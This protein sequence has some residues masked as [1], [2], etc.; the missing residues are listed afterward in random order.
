MIL[1]DTGGQYSD[2]TTDITR[3]WYFGTPSK[4]E[5]TAYTAVLKAHIALEKLVF[6]L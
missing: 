1:I 6:P 2:G 5:K 4:E 3:V